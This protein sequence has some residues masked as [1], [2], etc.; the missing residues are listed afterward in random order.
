MIHSW[1][2]VLHFKD[3]IVKWE[4]DWENNKDEGLEKEKNEMKI[5]S[6]T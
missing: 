3:N 2:C 1:T 6:K 5:W 4:E